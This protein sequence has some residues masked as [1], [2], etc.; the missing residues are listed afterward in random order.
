MSPKAL[1]TIVHMKD[2]EAVVRYYTG[3]LGLTDSFRY[4][5]YAW[6]R[7]GSHELHITD[8]GEPRQIIGAGTA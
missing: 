4:G 2:L 5:T 6:L 1:N 8:P 7:L 3:V